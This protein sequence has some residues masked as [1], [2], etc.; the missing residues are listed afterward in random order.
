MATE[1]LAVQAASALN[2]YFTLRNSAGNYFDWHDNTF[3]ALASATTPYLTATERIA[4]AGAAWSVYVADLDLAEVAPNLAIVNCVA[5]AW[6]RS[7]GSP[8]LAVDT[9]I[10]ESVAIVA[11]WERL[12]PLPI[13]A[14][15]RLATRTTAGTQIELMAWLES[16]GIRVPLHTLDS[17]ATCTVDV[18]MRGNT[19]QFSLNSAAMGS[20]TTGHCFEPTYSNPNFTADRIYRANVT[21][22]ANGV[23]FGPTTH[24]FNVVP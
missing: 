3:K 10:S 14:K 19:S 4:K 23:T 1:T 16:E 15:V 22:V 18:L 5:Q 20:V 12:G 9:P 24:T 13:E 8:D 17:S 11:Q 6:R 7:G 21:I 2:V